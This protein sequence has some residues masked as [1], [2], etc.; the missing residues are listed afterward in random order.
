MKKW[1]VK[2]LVAVGAAVLV[3]S[4]LVAISSV[5]SKNAA[6]RYKDQLRS[7]GEKLDLKDLVPPR[8]DPNQNGR[9]LFTQA[10]ISMGS[11]SQG[12]LST[13]T[14]G[15]M[16]PVAPGKAMIGWQEA[17]II[18]DY[19]KPYTNSW[20][21]LEQALQLQSNSITFIRQASE[22]PQLDFEL[23]FDRGAMLLLPHVA[24]MKQSA[25]LFSSA[26]VAEVHY[27]YDHPPR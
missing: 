7:A 3:I 16:R 9:E 4:S 23:D 14:P 27:Y 6:E 13:N 10:F 20:A 21:D 17:E 24:K 12:M 2:T 26:T 18:S 25:L 22:R 5:H 1:W 8:V 11:F 19:D 15:A